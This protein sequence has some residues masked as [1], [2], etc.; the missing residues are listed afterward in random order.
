MNKADNQ[1]SEILTIDFLK[2]ISPI[3]DLSELVSAVQMI[4]SDISA[5]DLS[6]FF[7]NLKSFQKAGEEL[8]SD[9]ELE[10]VVGGA[11]AAS[12]I[13]Y[14]STPWLYEKMVRKYTDHLV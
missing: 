10:Y 8:L 3:N 14:Q 13:L 12:E 5:D 4:R 9:E 2:S 1:L 11:A 7:H 6:A